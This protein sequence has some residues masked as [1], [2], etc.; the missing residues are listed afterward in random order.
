MS[1]FSSTTPR[2]KPCSGPLAFTPEKLRAW[3]IYPRGFSEPD[4]ELNMVLPA[5]SKRS[6]FYAERTRSPNARLCQCRKRC[7]PRRSAQDCCAPGVLPLAHAGLG[8]GP[9]RRRARPRSEPGAW[10]GGGR[11]PVPP[12]QRAPTQARG[13]LSA[14]GRRSWSNTTPRP[15]GSCTLPAKAGRELHTASERNLGFRPWPGGHGRSGRQPEARSVGRPSRI[16]RRALLGVSAL[17]RQAPGHLECIIVQN[18]TNRPEAD[19]LYPRR[20]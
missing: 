4:V 16:L 11:V 10:P 14:S 3:H 19:R 15:A 6:D 17:M 9:R 13:P 5:C 7:S 18:Q 8:A 20:A 2:S 1:C 12:G